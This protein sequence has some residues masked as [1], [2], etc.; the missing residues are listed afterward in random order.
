MRAVVQRVREAA[1]YVEGRRHASMAH[2]MVVLL[3]VALSDTREDAERLCAKLVGLRIFAD[4]Q[5]NM[6]RSLE[7]VQGHVL[8]VS[9]FTLMASTAKGN[10]P[11]FLNAAKPP[12]A[13]PLYEHMYQQFIQRLPGR[14]HTGV[15]GADM[16][17]QLVNDGPVTL[18]LDTNTKE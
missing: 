18:V 9:Q 2:G 11:S 15:F 14:V 6:N 3:G 17:V 4:E 10:R 8:L 5:G 7:Q 16:Q 12:E 1:V 13:L